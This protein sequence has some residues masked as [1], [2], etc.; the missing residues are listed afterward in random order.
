MIGLDWDSIRD[1]TV[2]IYFILKIKPPDCQ[3][4]FFPIHQEGNGE[5]LKIENPCHGLINKLIYN[6]QHRILRIA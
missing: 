4:Y 1:I 5:I 2:N 6:T 3:K